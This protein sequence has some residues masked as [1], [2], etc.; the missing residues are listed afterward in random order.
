MNFEHLQAK[1]V[2]T[3]HP[4]TTKF[5]WLSNQHRD[6]MASHIGHHDFLSY[7]ALAQNNSV[8]RVR[9]EMLERMLQPCGP[10]PEREEGER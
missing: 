3:G 5:E 1:Y 8:A 10:P 4:D 6:T 7:V 9:Y 2:G